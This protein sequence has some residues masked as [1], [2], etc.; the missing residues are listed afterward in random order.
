MEERK[1]FPDIPGVALPNGPAELPL[2]DFGPDFEKGI[3]S[4]RRCYGRIWLY[5]LV[6]ATDGDGNDIGGCEPQ[7]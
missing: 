1:G 2:L 3:I 4:N 6:P 5:H 7:W